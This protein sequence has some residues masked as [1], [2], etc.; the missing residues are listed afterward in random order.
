MLPL[1]DEQRDLAGEHA[2]V[3]RGATRRWIGRFP[4]LR[5]EIISDAGIA[6]LRAA[7]DYRTD[8][9]RLFAVFAWRSIQW[10]MAK[11]IRRGHERITEQITEYNEPVWH[12]R[13]DRSTPKTVEQM[14]ANLPT[15]RN[16]AMWLAFRCDLRQRYIAKLLKSRLLDVKAMRIGSMRQLRRELMACAKT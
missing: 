10:Q 15:D 5:D 16:L 1:T 11:T 7:R 3:V 14:I 12:D 9:G 4:W 8:T 6:L 13:D 2:S